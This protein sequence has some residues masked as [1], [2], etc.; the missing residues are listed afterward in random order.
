MGT[1]SGTLPRQLPT[2]SDSLTS[3]SSISSPKPITVVTASL[4][5]S[6]VGAGNPRNAAVVC[7]RRTVSITWAT[8]MSMSFFLR[9][10]AIRLTHQVPSSSG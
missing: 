1:A 4:Y 6:S 8:E 9:R 7:A 3:C 10:A 5:S 2:M